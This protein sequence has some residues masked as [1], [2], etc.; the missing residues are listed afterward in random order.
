MEFLYFLLIGAV[1]GWLA[2]FLFKGG[3]FGLLGNII[4]GIIGA[5]FGGW[6]AQQIGVGGG[7]LL[8]HVVIAAIGGWIV[9]SLIGLFKK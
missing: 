7:G 5:L 1:S 4:L 8:W 2:G 3:G 9:L 6:L